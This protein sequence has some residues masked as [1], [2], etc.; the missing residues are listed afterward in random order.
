MILTNADKKQDLVAMNRIIYM[1]GIMKQYFCDPR[2]YVYLSQTQA[3]YKMEEV[4]T[5]INDAIQRYQGEIP[6]NKFIYFSKKLS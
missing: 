2:Y 1:T 3:D 5:K 6:D 4:A